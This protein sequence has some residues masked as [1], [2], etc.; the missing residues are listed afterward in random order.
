MAT[1]TRTGLADPEE[2]PWMTLQQAAI[3]IAASVKTIRR[4]IA[5]G[6]LKAY[7]CGKRGLRVRRGD[8][9]D[10]MRPI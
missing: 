6:E 7:V 10:L 2:N 3:Y 4:R 9:D 1:A 8:L 5:A